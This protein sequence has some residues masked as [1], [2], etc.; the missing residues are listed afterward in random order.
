MQTAIVICCSSVKLSSLLRAPSKL[1]TQFPFSDLEDGK[2][3]SIFIF[4][5][6]EIYMAIV[7]TLCGKVLI[8][9][10]GNFL[11]KKNAVLPDLDL[12]VC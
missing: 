1:Y 3:N 6:L 8:P 11:D 5:C 9:I 4:L 7:Y 2:T 12:N 10:L